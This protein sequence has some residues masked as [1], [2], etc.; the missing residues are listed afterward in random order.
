[1]GTLASMRTSYTSAKTVSTFFFPC[2]PR[3]PGMFRLSFLIKAN[4]RKYFHYLKEIS[5]K[6]LKRVDGE[7]N[8]AV[9]CMHIKR[10]GRGVHPEDSFAES[11]RWWKS[12]M[13][14]G[15]E[16]HFQARPERQR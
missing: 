11:G 13:K 10:C 5:E 16:K 8:E 4:E 9:E 6:Y 2:F 15:M 14:A 3:D 12:R 7:G 1:M